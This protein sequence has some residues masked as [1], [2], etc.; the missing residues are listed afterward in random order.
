MSSESISS[1]N[2][3]VTESVANGKIEAAKPEVT[4]ETEKTVELPRV[5][6]KPEEKKEK[7]IDSERFAILSKKHRQIRKQQEELKAQ[8][9]EYEAMKQKIQ[10]LEGLKAKATQDPET[11]LK[12]VYGEDWYKH[13]T[14]FVLNDKKVPVDL[15]VQALKN[16]LDEFKKQQQIERQKYVELEKQRIAQE[17]EQTI[18][19]FKTEVNAFVKAN[20]ESL[21]LTNINDGSNLVYDVI[22]EHYEKTKQLMPIKEAADLVEKYYEAQAQKLISAKKIASKINGVKST[23]EKVNA[24]PA[25]SPQLKRTITND[26]SANSSSISSGSKLSEAERMRRAMARLEG[27]EP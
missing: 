1:N 8:K 9:S 2:V 13:I 16:E 26:L 22:E 15:H 14:D 23:P 7:D 18:N 20:A 19:Q 27:R 6:A 12:G 17:R 5:E 3:V 25:N 21:E 4:K 11:F 10:E 24:E